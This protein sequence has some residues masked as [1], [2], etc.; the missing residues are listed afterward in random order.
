MNVKFAVQL[1]TPSIQTLIA[2]ARQ[3]LLQYQ[4]RW[5]RI[6]GQFPTCRYNTFDYSLLSPKLHSGCQC[7]IKWNVYCM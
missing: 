4:P 7:F 3:Y 6:N 5:E 1:S 2:S